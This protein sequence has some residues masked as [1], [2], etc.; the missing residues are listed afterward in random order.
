MAALSREG[1]S[2]PQIRSSVLRPLG[3]GSPD[4]VSPRDVD[5]YI[6]NCFEYENEVIET[7][8]APRRMFDEIEAMGTFTGDCDD[9]SI[10]TATVLR[11]LGIQS[12]FVAIRTAGSPVEFEHVFTEGL[13]VT[14]IVPFSYAW[15]RFDATVPVDTV[16][17][18]A[19]ALVEYV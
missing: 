4:L 12:R 7:L 11:I 1:A 16:H 2:D 10:F 6:R 19:E 8:K 14:N 18:Y 17:E 5:A 15:V 3:W 9:V 13:F